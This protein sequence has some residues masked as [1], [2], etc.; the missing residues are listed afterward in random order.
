M[1]KAEK[2]PDDGPHSIEINV[3]T[4]IF[5]ARR[6][7]AS[8]KISMCVCVCVSVRIFFLLSFDDLFYLSLLL[9]VVCTEHM[10][11]YFQLEL[12]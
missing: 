12:R 7:V 1:M 6:S 9:Y 8:S 10:E 2:A 11:N 4:E 5:H 3:K